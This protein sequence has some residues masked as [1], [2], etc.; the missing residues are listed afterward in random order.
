M[1]DDA[2]LLCAFAEQA[3]EEAFTL[4]VERHLGLVYHSALRR[5]GGDA[6]RARDVAQQVF[7]DLA[8][9]AGRLSRHT[10]LQA[11]LYTSTRYA[12]AQMIRDDRRRNE[13][14]RIAMSDESLRQPSSEADWNAIQPLLDEAM[15]RL[16]EKDR[17]LI[18]K[19]F[20]EG[21]S[22]AELA[23]RFS[24]SEDA[25]RMRTNR[26]LEKLRADFM[27]KGVASSAAALGTALMS[28]SALSAPAGMAALVSASALANA[29]SAGALSAVIVFLSMNKVNTALI[30][31]LAI[32]GTAT[33]VLQYRENT[34]LRKTVAQ[35]SAQLRRLEKA[36]SGSPAAVKE[37]ARDPRLSNQAPTPA[38]AVSSPNK[39]S[40]ETSS[41]LAPGMI[42]IEKLAGAGL[43]TPR[44]AFATQLWAA[45]G[46]DIDLE[47]SSIAL[48]PVARER[49]AALALQMPETI[50]NQYN[51]PERLMAYLLAGSPR[52]V[53]GMEVL[54]ET[55]ED[56]ENAILH[57]QWQHEG[58]DA[59][60]TNDVHMHKSGAN[61]QMM[62]SP[63]LVER[64][65][66]YLQNKQ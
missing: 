16:G 21:A 61:W 57:V 53:S 63:R 42:P 55:V 15:D 38:I 48:G 40:N 58:S 11:W 5:L 56:P 32:G 1:I 22:F 18:L 8:Q 27:R 31:A 49:L 4:L 52:P 60:N 46:G 25:A 13:R 54:N 47:A 66:A 59:V 20:F 30:C 29:S 14:E 39:P 41:T 33:V 43:S 17:Q 26:A 23:E 7:S 62:I 64:A 12:S 65:A 44:N 45:R 6:H 35:Q 19:R 2:E 51:T 36:N 24:L 34:A 37:T 10:A 3:S 28:Q 9:K 50:R